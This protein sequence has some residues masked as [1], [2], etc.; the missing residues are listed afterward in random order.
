MKSVS[1]I[2]ARNS[3]NDPDTPK[4]DVESTAEIHFFQFWH[5]CPIEIKLD[6]QP[7]PVFILRPLFV[8]MYD[9]R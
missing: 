5:I 3:T 2:S 4:K 8:L 7:L 1:D 6:Y 9:G